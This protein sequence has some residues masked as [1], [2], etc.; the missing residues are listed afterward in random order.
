VPSGVFVPFGVFVGFG[1]LVTFG[2]LD[3]VDVGGEVGTNVAVFVGTTIVAEGVEVGTIVGVNVLVAWGGEVET[4]VGTT[5]FVGDGTGVFPDCL[6]G[7][8]VGGFGVGTAVGV[9]VGG[10]G[11][12]PGCGV[13]LGVAVF[14]GVLE[15][16][17]G[18]LTTG[19]G[20][21]PPLG[22][23]TA[24]N[25]PIG[26]GVGANDASVGVGERI[27]RGVLITRAV[28]VGPSGVSMS[29]ATSR[30]SVGSE[31]ASAGSGVDVGS[32]GSVLTTV[33]AEIVGRFGG[34]GLSSSSLCAGKTK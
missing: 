10:R 27:A 26:V 22:G 4:L 34:L 24:T 21:S 1:V 33:G 18:G 13:L 31:V 11:V 3:G 7:V 28:A 5:V 9:L 6:V 32:A 15:G 14:V 19:G 25:V 23:S 2:S 12:T 17:G 20:G 29:S 8:A 16:A 30:T